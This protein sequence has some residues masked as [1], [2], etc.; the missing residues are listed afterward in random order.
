MELVIV[1]VIWIAMG[2]IGAN[3]LER[4]GFSRRAGL[5]IGALLGPIG[6]IFALLASFLVSLFRRE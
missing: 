5:Y 4:R 6:I 2:F 1:L 3:I